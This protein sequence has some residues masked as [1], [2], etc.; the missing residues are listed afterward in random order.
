ML[1][2]LNRQVY[3]YL[4]Q[5]HFYKGT[6]WCRTWTRWGY[7]RYD[8][9]QGTLQ[10]HHKV[11]NNIKLLLNYIMAS[12]IH[13]MIYICYPIKLSNGTSPQLLQ[14][15]SPTQSSIGPCSSGISQFFCS[16][17][18]W[19]DRICS[20]QIKRK[21]CHAKLWAE[22]WWNIHEISMKYL[23]HIHE[24]SIRNIHEWIKPV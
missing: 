20:T 15:N 8:G 10:H 21:K 6:T 19:P 22:M 14:Q 11:S 18:M 23:W 12:I 4:V 24:I 2:T 1:P 13:E 5:G 16:K 3:V 17:I 7:S 9:G